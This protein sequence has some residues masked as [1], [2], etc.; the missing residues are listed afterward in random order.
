MTLYIQIPLPNISVFS[1]RYYD[2][3]GENVQDNPPVN[4]T[5]THCL[6][7]TA[8]LSVRAAKQIINEFPGVTVTDKFPEIWVDR[9]TDA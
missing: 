7:G 9:D 3:I 1:K 4:R 6:V 5:R 2:L 8:R